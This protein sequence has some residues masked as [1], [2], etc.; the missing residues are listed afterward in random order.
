MLLDVGHANVVAGFMG[1]ETATLIEPVLDAVRLFHVHDNLGARL[2]RRGRAD[3][4]TPCSSTSTFPRAAAT[5]PGT[6]SARLS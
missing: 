5:C 2:R 4:S 1:V 6:R 3:R